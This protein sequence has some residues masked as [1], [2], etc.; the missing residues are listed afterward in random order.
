MIAAKQFDPVLGVDIHIVQPP[1][2]V[3]PIPIPHPFIG[4]VLDPMDFIPVVGG[5]VM[6]NGIPR[7]T[8]GS[9]GIAAPPHIPIGGM[10]V[11]PPGN[12]CEVFM[13]SATVLADD[14]PLSRLGMPALSCH[15]IGMPSPPRIKKKSKARSL[16]LPTSVVL[17]IPAGPPVLVGGPPTVSMMAIGMRLGMSALGKG[18]KKLR[19][20]RKSSRR[21]KA[22]S[23]KAHAAAK[24]GMDKLG[25]PPSVRNRVHR[26]ICTVTGHPVD[27]ATGKVLTEEVEL[28]LAGPVPFRW[29]RVWYSTSVY[30][31]PLGHGWHH[32]YDLAL[33]EEEG[34][35]AVRL[36]DG[37]PLPFLPL[38]EG[39]EHFDRGEKLTLF[40]DARG[41]A[42]R[43]AHGLAFRFASAPAGTVCPL[44][45]VEDRCGNAIRF[46]Y[47]ARGR[48]A[49]ITDS[50]GRE[51]SVESDEEGHII[52]LVAP[53]P[54]R[55]GE[56]FRAVTYRYDGHGD[57][58]AAHDAHAHSI[59]YAWREHLLVC[60]TDRAGLSFHF[61][62]DGATHE[63]RCLR[64][65]GDGGLFG[66]EL[67]YDLPA[68]QTTVTDT[69]GGRT[70]YQCDELGLV[71]RMVDALGNAWLTEWNEYGEHVSETDPLGGESRYVHDGR[72]NLVEVLDPARCRR[73]IAYDAAD[74]PVEFADELGNSWKHEYDGRGCLLA[75]TDP[76]GATYRYER[77]ARGLLLAV[78]DPLGRESRIEWDDQGNPRWIVDRAGA[79]TYLDHDALGRMVRRTDAEGGEMRLSRD[80]V[81]R[82]VGL[83]DE[84]GDTCAFTYDARGN[85]VREVD[86]L[87][88][89]T[90]STYGMLDRLLAET[91][92]EGATFTCEYDGEGELAR[93]R[94]ATGRAWTL[95]RDLLGRVVE[96]RQFSGRRLRYAYDESG[97]VVGLEN[98]AGEATRLR[99][100]M[101]GR[102]TG[103]V[104]PGGKEERFAYDAAGQLLCAENAAARVEFEYDPAGRVVREALNGT[105][106]TSRYD[107]LGNRVERAGPFGRVLRMAYDAEERLA[108]VADPQGTLL[109]FRYDRVGREVRRALPGD[110]V[111][112]RE[113]L[114]THDLQAQRTSSPVARLLDRRYRWDAA[115]QMVLA[116]TP[117]RGV[118]RYEHDAAGRLVAAR[119]PDGT[120]SRYAYD[121]AGNVPAAPLDTGPQSAAAGGVDGWTLRFDADGNLVEKR[122]VRQAFHY[123]YDGA[124]N[125]ARVERGDGQVVEFAYDALG[126]R[127]QKR[128]GG[129]VV[130]LLWDEDVP[131]GERVR[132]SGPDAS[133]GAADE[134]EFVF[135]PESFE[136]LAVLEA[137]HTLLLEGDALGTPCLAVDRDGRSVWRAGYGPFG[138]PPA[139]SGTDEIPFRFP[140]QLED[141]ETGLFYNRFRYYDPE[142][143]MY[144]QPDP[145]GLCG[146]LNLYNYVPGPTE[147]I[148]PFGLAGTE[149]AGTQRWKNKVTKSGR[150]Y[151]KPGPK[152]SANAA[153][154]KKIRQIIR[155][156][157]AAGLEHIGGGSKTEIVIKTPGG[158]KPYRRADASF[159]DPA[160]GKITHHNVG[161]QNLNG[162]PIARERR[163]LDDI[164]DYAARKHR[165]IK[166]HPYKKP[167]R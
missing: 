120:V 134:R 138:E 103:R 101:L 135:W 164:R 84:A 58:V 79:V 22:L 95:H 37:R 36:A 49:G 30:D 59:R 154:N 5:T 161:L 2:P 75:L 132:G 9:A 141:R 159:R 87:G 129:R 97:E 139:G 91:D 100:D 57:L 39:E 83:R 45:S 44:A 27:V 143:R 92:A 98:G 41:Y 67:A 111:S 15:D 3:P 8:A 53:H 137:G 13:G 148:D 150:P 130:D 76:A 50:A 86:E 78:T 144:T 63:A 107:P 12:E 115:G 140:G 71:T 106:L 25:V 153:H 43:D 31:G 146:G 54:D 77:D 82:V 149:G 52:A 81:G 156:E 56:T 35:V 122:G 133:R 136:P 166:F 157:R 61:E 48:L 33:L 7:A 110:V 47:D 4:M 10:F 26:S 151:R 152:T 62:Y 117:E 142:L 20:L 118:T 1:G 18:L 40:R 73:R 94:D 60:E 38:A 162:T 32:S 158:D 11:K 21:M 108:E 89:V 123:G 80:L 125:L 145:V 155:Q 104:L 6:V 46:R 109:E 66:R 64:T 127:V 74:N 160:T 124:G 131:L 128:V 42:L 85:V 96:E 121:R 34:A 90:R 29:E 17:S 68:R 119:A 102:L 19:K 88:R 23:K 113:Y 126:R 105:V 165:S 69:R 14:E 16:F 93:V 72:G 163:A 167:C 114:P 112:E 28:E 24:K 99:R 55:P 147:W 116:G 65:W 70:L 51:L